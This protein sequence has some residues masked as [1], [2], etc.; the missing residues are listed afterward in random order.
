MA[1]Q[2]GVIGMT[3]L[4]DTSLL[5]VVD[6]S[7][8]TARLPHV[9]STYNLPTHILFAIPPQL[10]PGD[11]LVKLN[12]QFVTE[13]Q[14]MEDMLDSA[15]GAC[16]L[17]WG[18]SIKCYSASCICPPLCPKLALH[19]HGSARSAVRFHASQLHRPFPEPSTP[20]GCPLQ[21]AARCM[22][23][24]SVA[25]SRWR[26]TSECRTCTPVRPYMPARAC[27]RMAAMRSAGCGPRSWSIR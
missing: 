2:G 15:G 9:E 6:L 12:G 13:F 27:L 14:T 16:L 10:E 8:R 18:C 1:W 25:A 17:V 5:V 24:W 11:V 20:A 26:Q 19:L 3:S 4:R 21:W 22:W 23:R 7:L